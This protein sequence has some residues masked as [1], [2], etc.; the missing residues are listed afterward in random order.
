M[1][2]HIIPNVNYFVKLFVGY[3]DVRNYCNAKGARG[4]NVVMQRVNIYI[5]QNYYR[6]NY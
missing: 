5:G 3:F 6:Q 1:I 2:K 4:A